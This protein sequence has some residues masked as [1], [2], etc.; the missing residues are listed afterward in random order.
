MPTTITAQSGAVIKQNTRIAVAGCGVRILSRRVRGHRLILKVRTLG[1]GL[2]TVKGKG[3]RTVHRRVRKSS[4]VTF[5]LALTRGGLKLLHRHHPLSVA[6]H[7]DFKPARR[8]A[9]ESATSTTVRF[10]R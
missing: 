7:V 6:V 9:L 10:R 5:K 8:G 3:L 2:L 4:T 1:G